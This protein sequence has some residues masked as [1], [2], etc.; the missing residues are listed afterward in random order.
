MSKTPRTPKPKIP[1]PR[2]TLGQ[3]L[4]DGSRKVAANSL[5]KGFGVL[6]DAVAKRY[7]A[8]RKT[9]V[10][11]EPNSTNK[12]INNKKI[13]ATGA[14]DAIEDSGKQVASAID[15]VAINVTRSFARVERQ[16]GTMGD[17]VSKSLHELNS[18]LNR[19]LYKAASPPPIP[20]V[21]SANRGAQ[22][23]GEPAPDNDDS[24]GGGWWK[25][26][27]GAFA[28]RVA[29]A[30]GKG[31]IKGG[32]AIGTYEALKG[33]KS[34]SQT[35]NKT[36]TWLRGLL[37]I[38]DPGEA[39]PWSGAMSNQEYEDLKNN[40][41][42]Q[43]GKATIGGGDN[44]IHKF[45]YKAETITFKASDSI[46]FKTKKQQASSSSSSSTA[47]PAAGFFNSLIDSVGSGNGKGMFNSLADKATGSG[48]NGIS[49]I[50]KKSSLPS[51]ADMAAKDKTWYGKGG[52]GE[53]QKGSTNNAPGITGGTKAGDGTLFNPISSNRL[54]GK[55]GS[56]SASLG[57]R[58]HQGVDMMAAAGSPVYAAKDGT[59]TKIGRDNF[60]QP[61][62]TIKH[63]DGTY[64][65]YLHMKGVDTK[66]GSRVEGGKPIGTS[67]S[68]N[69]VD[70]LH[71]ERWNKQPNGAGEGLI[72]PR[73][74]FG[75]GD[76][77]RP[78]ITG[79]EK[80]GNA[81]EISSKTESTSSEENPFYK[82]NPF[83]FGKKIESEPATKFMQGEAT[84]SDGKS[85]EMDTDSWSWMRKRTDNIED[86]TDEDSQQWTRPNA[87][88]A[89]SHRKFAHDQ[90]QATQ[91]IPQKTDM[92]VL[93]GSNNLD[94][95]LMANQMKMNFNNKEALKPS[96]KPTPP[97]DITER[98]KDKH[99]F[100]HD[101]QKEN[102]NLDHRPRQ[103]AV[104]DLTF[105]DYMGTNSGTE[106]T[107]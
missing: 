41:T 42:N 62:V 48:G 45:K 106:D 18:V 16:V 50:D 33:M 86:R 7:F 27:A 66:V 69:G 51:D 72:N 34:D 6:G 98:K 73:E 20:P 8:P 103:M 93:L 97:K 100:M 89:A 9:N 94:F 31:A 59:I 30:V 43:P 47:K 25:L 77:A 52:D 4:K 70:H 83:G 63:D 5:R 80:V 24:A 78:K 92:G 36:R 55:P 29:S 32:A 74:E 40:Q 88:S 35:G 61:T 67:G 65:R 91:P 57:A 76:G 96:I 14:S 71:F 3:T 85:T 17:E 26:A 99:S 81:P 23:S 38:E 22:S 44:I 13:R 64:S 2:K 82:K 105:G 11:V 58:A 107:A 54:S 46:E 79:G 37:G 15:A 95:G 1:K 56:D 21:V 10:R 53:K 84:G 101:T 12:K 39:A 28:G 49:G 104:Q 90:W 60:N 68:A 75:W 19:M 102:S 87:M